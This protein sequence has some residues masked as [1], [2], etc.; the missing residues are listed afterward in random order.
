MN[1]NDLIDQFIAA[2]GAVETFV[3]DSGVD[4][5]QNQY[6][7]LAYLQGEFKNKML[8]FKDGN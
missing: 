6:D 7:C 3:N 1:F 4:H 8:A 2:S 5:T